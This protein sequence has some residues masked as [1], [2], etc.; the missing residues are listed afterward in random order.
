VRRPTH[1]HESWPW[2]SY[3][4]TAGLAPTPAFLDR[5]W[6]LEQ[7]APERTLA[8]RR[9][10]AYIRGGLEHAQ[11]DQTPEGD[12]YLASKPFIRGRG[13]ATNASPE[14]PRVQREPIPS[15]LE[16]LS[17]AETTKR[18]CAPTTNTATPC[19]R[20][21]THSAST[22]QPSAAASPPKNAPREHARDALRCKT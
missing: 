19:A 18:S 11:A 13:G 7:F 14:I 17:S 2:S 9:Y 10:R 21:P 8:Q 6:L 20:S 16:Q 15:T 1:T 12:L 22:T 5:D 4:A 3:Q